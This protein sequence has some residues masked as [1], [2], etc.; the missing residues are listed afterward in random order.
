[1]LISDKKECEGP[2]DPFKKGRVIQKH[3]KSIP[4]KICAINHYADREMIDVIQ[5]IRNYQ[6]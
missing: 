4:D 5:P 2:E 1:M 3:Q 6:N